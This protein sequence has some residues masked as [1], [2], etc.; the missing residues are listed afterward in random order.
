M[1]RR[2]LKRIVVPVDGSD[3]ALKA[4]EFVRLLVGSQQ[5]L[6]L[7]LL[8]VL[9]GLPPALIENGRKDPGTA[10]V[11]PTL[12]KRRREAAE[13]LIR[14]AAAK[15]IDC[16]F[17]SETARGTVLRRKIGIARDIAAWSEEHRADAICISSRGL[18]R[19]GAFF[20]GEI[21]NK[22]VECARR[23][24]VWVIK[25]TVRSNRVLVAIDHSTNARRA[26]Q[27]AGHLLAGRAVRVTIFHARRDLQRFIPQEVLDE[28]PEFQRFWH[29][30]ADDVLAPYVE[31]AREML[32]EAG[33][34]G[35]SIRVQMA[36]GSGNTASDILRAAADCGAGSIIMGKHGISEAKNFSMGSIS[37]K[38]LMQ[39]TDLAVCLVP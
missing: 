2:L 34:P 17:D 25:G 16:G 27:H 21:A 31:K 20:L 9:P 3:N 39:S 14:R 8:H 38:V 12:E 19:I 32:T 5:P 24:P 13:S 23:C 26:V 10:A 29:R 15:A 30:R 22:L 7:D 36:E 33:I 1:C 35:E 11:L 6:Q 28:F 18:S 4:I 37:K